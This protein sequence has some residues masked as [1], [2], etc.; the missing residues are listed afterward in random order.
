LFVVNR[1]QM[2]FSATRIATDDFTPEQVKAIIAGARQQIAE[3]EQL[4][5]RKIWIFLFLK[6]I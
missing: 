2:D 6:R 3:E 5:K 4:I 1:I